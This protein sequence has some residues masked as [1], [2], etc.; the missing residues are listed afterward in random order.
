M[1]QNLFFLEVSDSKHVFFQN[2]A[3]RNKLSKKVGKRQLW[4][5]NGVKWQKKRFFESKLSKKAWCFETSLT[6]KSVALLKFPSK[7]WCVV[8]K[9]FQNPTRCKVSDPKMTV[10][11]KLTKNL[12]ILKVLIRIWR[13]VENLFQDLIFCKS[14]AR[15]TVFF[16]SFFKNCWFSENA[17]LQIFFG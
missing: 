3:L 11:V 13:V 16:H 7:T 10:C 17:W 1:I 4:H 14:P 9:M 12:L 8:K 5:F 6:R 2:I 15:K